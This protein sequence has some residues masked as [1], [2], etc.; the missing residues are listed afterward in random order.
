MSGT[1]YER[2]WTA[3]GFNPAQAV[4]ASLAA[5][6][7]QNV[8]SNERCLDVGCG[9]G[10]GPAS[11]LS[12]RA[13]SY[14]GVDVSHAAVDTARSAGLDV[15]HIDDAS[16]LPFPD[17]SFDVVTCIEVLEH[18][19]AP[20]DA[21]RQALRVLRPG[22]RFLVTVPNVAYWR[23]RVDLAL[24]GRWNPLGDDQSAQ[25][26]WRDPHL[27]FFG[28]ANL[29]A[30]LAEAGFDPVSTGGHGGSWRRDIPRLRRLAGSGE[31]GAVYRRLTARFPTLFAHH[32][33]AVATKP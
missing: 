17:G 27:R 5:F 30:M 31:P 14:V 12:H 11:W 23:R 19:V 29:R 20:V 15:R 13:R 1:D 6:L 10:G 24:L 7:E 32:L 28:E 22:G 33:H 2:Y 25:R 18:L 8:R 26:P 21:A 16:A 4:P 3:K 9:P